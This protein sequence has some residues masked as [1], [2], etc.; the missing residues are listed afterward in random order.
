MVIPT[1]FRE[2]TEEEVPKSCQTRGPLGFSHRGEKP[3]VWKRNTQTCNFVGLK[4]TR[5]KMGHATGELGRQL[6]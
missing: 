6:S 3:Q 4:N 5:K 1:D 2:L